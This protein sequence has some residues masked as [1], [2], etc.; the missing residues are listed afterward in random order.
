MSLDASEDRSLTV[1]IHGFSKAGK[2]SLSISAPAPRL[3]LDVESASRFL[4]IK[5][6]RW[7]VDGPPPVPDGTW[8]T[9]IV[10]T[11]DYGTVEKVY[12]WLNS[13]KHPFKSLI[14]DSISELQKRYFEKIAGRKQLT[15]QQWGEAGRAVGGLV[16]DVRDLTMH[17]IKP[18]ECVV[19]T[20]M[21]RQLNNKYVPW[22]QGQLQTELPYLMDAT[23]YLF[24]D[25]VTNEL[26]GDTK[27]IRRLLTRPTPEFE[28]G[29]RV[30]G[31]WPIVIDK[32]NIS[33]MIDA[34]FGP[35]PSIAK[36][37]EKPKAE[38]PQPKKEQVSN[39]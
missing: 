23:T 22:C 29:E 3:Y 2:S 26:T 13:G 39:V 19:M 10:P 31:V 18:L 1:L 38:E 17:P 27:E 5:R 4:P 32:P 11:L 8:D 25:T 20:A 12:Q 7:D 21:T 28:A 36:N 6:I 30:G 24:V 34:V 14:I 9:A 33:K 35:D 37:P 16:R 15:Q